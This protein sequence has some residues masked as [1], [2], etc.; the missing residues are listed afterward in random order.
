LG[1]GALGE[2]SREELVYSEVT[3]EKERSDALTL[4]M[5]SAESNVALEFIL[6][7]ALDKC[8]IDDIGDD[9]DPIPGAKELLAFITKH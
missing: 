7:S 9:L 4:L 2:A 5:K 6:T 3:K 1:R 8:S